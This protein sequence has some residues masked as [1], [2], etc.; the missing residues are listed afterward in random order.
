[1]DVFELDHCQFHEQVIIF[2]EF[3]VI[4]LRPSESSQESLP[5]VRVEANVVFAIARECG[6][7]AEALT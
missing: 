5:C 7:H 1:V 6:S 4:G 2:A 3:Y